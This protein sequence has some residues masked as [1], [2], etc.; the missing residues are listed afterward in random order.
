MAKQKL[1]LS[2]KKV[3]NHNLEDIDDQVADLEKEL[4]DED[5]DDTEDEDEDSDD[6]D[7][8]EDGNSDDES[9]DDDDDSGEDEGDEDS[10]G[11]DDEEAKAAARKKKEEDDQRKKD[12]EASRQEALIQNARNKQIT[13]KIKEAKDL[14]V[15]EEELRAEAAKDGIDFETLDPS[16]KLLLKRA[17]LS[18]R[19]FS[20]VSDVFVEEGKTQE[21]LGKITEFIGEETTGQ[22]FPRLA[23]HTEQFKIFAMKPTRRGLDFEDLATLFLANI[24]Q[25]T[26]KK[27]KGS[28]LPRGNGGEKREKK[29]ITEDDVVAMR[30]INPGKVTDLMKKGKIKFD[31]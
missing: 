30:K 12:A 16:Q 21:W 28:L 24:P 1:V 7:N 20:T 6:N 8:S 14:Q 2:K 25:D 19:R 10:E 18:E 27:M 15:T 22:K 4:E 3:T 9:G 13:D 11:E 26:K 31:I 17:I 5:L 29:G 23:Q